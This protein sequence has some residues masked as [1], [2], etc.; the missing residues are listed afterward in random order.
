MESSIHHRII[1]VNGCFDVLHYG[2]L[3]LLSYA[4]SLGES[5]V[6]ALDSDENVA[7]SKPGRPVFTLTERM[8]MVSMLKPVDFVFSFENS[9]GLED[10]VCRLKPDVM[11]V[12]SDWKDKPIVGSQYAK[13]VKFF[14]RISNFSSTKIIDGIRGRGCL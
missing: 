13:E 12:G 11:V 5:L 10:L 2:H 8:Y 1:F 4:K 3:Q 7:K 9:Q 6:V 14:D